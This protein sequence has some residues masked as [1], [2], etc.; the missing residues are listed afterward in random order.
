MGNGII[1]NIILPNSDRL[2]LSKIN[3]NSNLKQWEILEN[4]FSD[5]CSQIFQ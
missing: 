1:P 3:W 4:S 5:N 2:N